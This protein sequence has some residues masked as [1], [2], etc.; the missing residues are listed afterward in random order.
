MKK[1]GLYLALLLASLM[2][3]IAFAKT[4]GGKE[5]ETPRSL[6]ERQA[7]YIADE[8]AFDDDTT[9]KFVEVYK[10]QKQELLQLR[11]PRQAKSESR[12]D[13]EV[14]RAIRERFVRSAKILELRKK[15]YEEYLT[16]LKPKQIE[17]VYRLE[18]TFVNRWSMGFDAKRYTYYIDSLGKSLGEKYGNLSGSHLYKWIKPQGDKQ[19]L[20]DKYMPLEIKAPERSGGEDL[21]V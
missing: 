4:Q 20:L 14:D 17:R 9:Q 1:I 12:T 21:D 8:L 13:K 10:R 15:H 3:S 6:S 11:E 16:F 19:D 5:R 18:Q 2:P 7:L